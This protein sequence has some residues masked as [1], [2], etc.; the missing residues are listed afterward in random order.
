MEVI[1][2][3]VSRTRPDLLVMGTSNRS[4]LSRALIGSVT[5]EALRSLKVDI[6][7]VPLPQAD[8][9]RPRE[10]DSAVEGTVH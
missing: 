8:Q 1:N 3:V 9:A 7:A 4:V 5:E 6:L 10:R 2:S